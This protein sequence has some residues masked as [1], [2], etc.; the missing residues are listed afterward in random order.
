MS[1][2]NELLAEMRRGSVTRNWGA[3]SAQSRSRTNRMLAE[4]Y[5]E[6][7]DQKSYIV[8][9]TAV[10]AL[11]D[12]G[13]LHLTGL[14]LGQPLLQFHTASMVNSQAVL[15][16]NIVAGHSMHKGPA[17]NLIAAFTLTEGH[18]F[19]VE[20]D[21]NLGMV[22]GEVDRHG[23]VTLDLS[24]GA[25]LRCNLADGNPMVRDALEKHLKARF[26]EM[27]ADR[28]VFQVGSVDLKGYNML[29]PRA[30]KIYTQPA[31]GAK[32][33]GAKNYG[34][35][36]VVIFIQLVGNAGPGQVPGNFPYLI[37]DDQDGDGNDRY[38]A[39]LVV[40]ESLLEHLSDDR[41]E[42]FDALNSLLY[43]GNN[44][45][46]KVAEYTPR[47]LLVVGNIDPITTRYQLEPQFT[48]IQAGESLSFTLRDGKGTPIQASRWEAVGMQ[49]H[50]TESQG[51]MKANV[52]TAAARDKLGH[53][54]LRVRVTA[55]VEK[56]GR[57]YR[58]SA[59]VL[60]NA[61][62]LR[63]AP[64]FSTVSSAGASASLVV[65]GVEGA[66]RWQLLGARQGSLSTEEGAQTR[67]IPDAD[68]ATRALVVQS[69]QALSGTANK[70]KAVVIV[71]NGKSTLSVEPAYQGQLK[72]GQSRQLSVT[73]NLLPGCTRRWKVLTEGASVS[74]GG[75]LT[76]TSEAN[77]S[78]CVVLI[79]EVRNGVVIKRGTS[80]LQVDD[81]DPEPTW[82]RLTEFSIRVNGGQEGE[83]QGRVYANG[84]QQLR[85]EI[86]VQPANEGNQETF[87]SED[88][89]NSIRLV[90]AKNDQ[91]VPSLPAD[92]EGIAEGGGLPAW[93]TN[94]V[95]NEKFELAN[96]I[97]QFDAA[98]ARKKELIDTYIHTRA[99]ASERLYAALTRDDNK[100][101]ASNADNSARGVIEVIPVPIPTF[102]DGLYTFTRRRMGKPPANKQTDENWDFDWVLD[103]V[104]YWTLT[105]RPKEFVIVEFLPTS[106]AS[107][108][109]PTSI[110][111]WESEQYEEAMFSY[112][113]W[114]F[115]S[116]VPEE[117][118]L[119]TVGFD[120]VL[121]SIIGKQRMT[122]AAEDSAV[123]FGSVVFV[124]NR[125]SSTPY[126]PRG[127]LA[128]NKMD[129]FLKLLARDKQGNPHHRVISFE[130]AG[131]PY[132]RDKLVH[133]KS[134]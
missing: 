22:V 56:D 101:F 33:F 124:L 8:P 65:A 81:V 114:L 96:G 109:P 64:G 72:P 84:Y 123:A 73:D 71:A 54:C 132:H 32:T 106:L 93:Q 76:T 85:T 4:Q 133:I 126:V 46:V 95:F 34:D 30:F 47:D 37:P 36:A 51:S 87:L 99:N 115:K 105:F 40:A 27:P 90:F 19:H 12:G 21:I 111:R 110:I 42:V 49:S 1:N 102:E 23:R 26:D 41:D 121:E 31:P 63:I 94:S 92:E 11:E 29:S 38:S 16:M 15:T 5:I 58:A 61:D 50:T 88:E 66:P 97:V 39:V 69:L 9:L 60:V 17:G 25:N 74:P 10:V 18:G 20:F 3:V 122:Q 117:S 112:L 104:D 28:R 131:T 89:I 2:L 86:T 57:T 53:A 98:S 80:V 75:L 125:S 116:T 79:E 13:T 119:G 14:T 100:E 24:K 82:T 55:S 107:S 35:G 91:G 103:S 44:A 134:A 67:F 68:T 113:G 52:Y 45:F 108:G 120:Y 129:K 77:A 83:R 59:L 48:S 70:A 130:T 7:L 43:P 6:R 62:P 127:A 128:R 78:P 118:K